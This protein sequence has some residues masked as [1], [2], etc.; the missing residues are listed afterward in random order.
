MRASRSGSRRRAAIAAELYAL[1][2]VLILASRLCDGLDGAVARADDKTDRGGFLDIVLDFAFYGVIPLAFV[3]ARAGGQCGRRRACSASFYVNGAS[4]LAYAVMAERRG[5]STEARGEKS[6]YFTSRLAEAT[7][8]IV[9]FCAVLPLSRRLRTDRARLRRADARHRSFTHR[10]G[11]AD[12]AVARWLRLNLRGRAAIPFCM[13]KGTVIRRLREH[14]AELRAE[15]ISHVYLFGSVARGEADERSDV[16]LFYDD[17]PD[18]FGFLQ[19]MRI[20]ELG[21]EIV[22]RAVDIMPRDGL[23]PLIR[24]AVERSAI[25]VF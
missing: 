11:S 8:T 9:V 2:L 17:D 15:G 25:E 5:L 14:E 4:F 7:E 22:G 12:A 16:D 6:L 23:H 1:G 21:P 20:R 19:F 3:L 10:P 24:A 13:D 18:R